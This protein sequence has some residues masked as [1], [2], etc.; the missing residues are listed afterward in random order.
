VTSATHIRM[1]GE[2]QC[3]EKDISLW[4]DDLRVWQQELSRAQGELK[5]LERAL[6]EHAN[7][8]RKH[9]SSLRLEEESI[10]PHEHEIAE[11]EKGGEGDALFEMARKHS[12]EGVDHARHR[13]VHEQLKR[14]HHTVIAHL[15]LLLKALGESAEGTPT[16]AITK[17]VCGSQ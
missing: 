7:V 1:H 8:L 16:P 13:E 15:N 5:Q 9:A 14:R 17:S 10:G 4:R 2:H 12:E 3:W 11:Y 6:E